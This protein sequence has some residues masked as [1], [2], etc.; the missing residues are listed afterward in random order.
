MFDPN[1]LAL[2]VELNGKEL[3][4][5]VVAVPNAG[6]EVAGFPNRLLPVVPNTLFVWPKPREVLVLPKRGLFS[7]EPNS[8]GPVVEV[9][10]AAPN[11]EGCG[12]DPNKPPL[13]C[14]PCWGPLR[15]AA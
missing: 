15:L 11:N 10:E 12:V 2:V 7:V 9:P 8:P 14:T 3:V 5:V 4:L 1:G 6:V 13:G